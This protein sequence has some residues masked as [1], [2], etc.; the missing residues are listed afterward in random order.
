MRQ[1]CFI[2]LLLSAA[3]TSSGAQTQ[4]LAPQT[5]RQALL[6]MFTGNGGGFEKHLP[7]VARHTLIRKGDT[8]TASIMEKLAS[9][10]RELPGGGDIQTFD[11]GPLL[12][13]KADKAGHEKLEIVLERDSLLGEEDIIE[14]SIRSYKEGQMEALPVVPRFV[15]SMAEEKDVWRLKEVTAEIHVPLSDQDYLDGLRKEQN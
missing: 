6:E 11:V 13:V 4:P 5:A 9:I 3:C 15:F 1:F 14:L 10:G 7:E 12:I 8:I 2:L